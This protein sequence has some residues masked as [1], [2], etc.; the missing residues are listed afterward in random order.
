[1]GIAMKLDISEK[2]LRSINNISESIY[3]GMVK[4]EWIR[5]WNCR[6]EQILVSFTKHLKS[7]QAKS[8]LRRFWGLQKKDKS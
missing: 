7:N 8:K 4:L 5:E 1:M 3:P 2:L 6:L